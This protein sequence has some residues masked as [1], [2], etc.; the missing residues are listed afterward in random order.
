MKFQKDIQLADLLPPGQNAERRTKMHHSCQNHSPYLRLQEFMN[1]GLNDLN[2][3]FPP[4]HWTYATW[5]SLAAGPIPKF[6]N[7]FEFLG[8]VTPDAAK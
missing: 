1:R 7:R 6:R 8:Q 3:T 4:G 5:S 2:L